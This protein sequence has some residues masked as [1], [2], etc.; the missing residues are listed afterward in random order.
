MVAQPNKRPPRQPLSPEEVLNFIRLKKHRK[1]KAIEHFKKTQR[2]KFLNGFNIFCI[3][4]Y[5]E[6]I[7]SFLGTCHYNAHFVKLADT[8]YGRNNKGDKR[9]CSSMVLTTVNDRIYD[10]SINDTITP[11]EAR[12][13]PRFLVGKDWI[14]QKEVTVK[15]YGGDGSFIIKDS[16]PILFISVL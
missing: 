7:L 16:F 4:I 14:L 1:L 11:P 13:H 10:I 15:F 5:T 9:I 2:Y 3:V 6:L 12:L 8:F